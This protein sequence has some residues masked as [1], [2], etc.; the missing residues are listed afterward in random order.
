TSARRARRRAARAACP[1]TPRA[2]AAAAAAPSS[3][4]RAPR[5]PPPPPAARR[6]TSRPPRRARARPAGR[7]P[8]PRR[9][10]RCRSSAAES[11][12][13]ARVLLDRSAELRRP[14]VGPERV[15]ERELRVGGLPQQEVRQPQLAG[16][17]DQE[18]GIR[19]LRRI[20]EAR[21]R[22]LVDGVSARGQPPRALDDLGPAAVVERDP[23]VEPRLARR[24]LLERVELRLQP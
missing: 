10:R 6:A 12:A 2:R 19:H 11:T 16:R 14:E 9:G 7:R 21:E 3:R 23:E 15:R 8:R 17:A 1:R 18:I 24:R 20:E 13:A 22:R 4:T 5:P